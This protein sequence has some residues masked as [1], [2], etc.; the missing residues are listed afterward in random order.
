[1]CKLNKPLYGRK[2][3]AKCWNLES[4]RYFLL[5]LGFKRFENDFCLHTKE[6]GKDGGKL[7]LLLYV[8][9]I[10]LTGPDIEIID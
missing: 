5:G 10:I 9:D 3:A 1:M 4:N 8:D 6:F 2:Q 7:Y